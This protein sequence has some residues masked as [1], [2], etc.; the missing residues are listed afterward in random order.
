MSSTHSPS[1]ISFLQFSLAI[2]SFCK[3]FQ[4]CYIVALNGCHFTN[5]HRANYCFRFFFCATFFSARRHRFAVKS[6]QLT[7]GNA[8]HQ[9]PVEHKTLSPPIISRFGY[10]NDSCTLYP[11]GV[12]FSYF[13]KQTTFCLEISRICVSASHILQK[14]TKWFDFYMKSTT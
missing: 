4:L 1:N 2:L 5:T 10:C 14:S 7:S 9:R 11:C 12:V 3:L 13:S 6:L 8:T